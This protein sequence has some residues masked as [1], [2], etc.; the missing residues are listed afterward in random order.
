[1][2]K[3]SPAVSVI[4]PLYNAEKYLGVCLESLL[5]Q[6][7]TDFEIIVVDDCS[8][9]ASPAVAESYLERFGGRLKIVTLEKNTGSGAVPRN[10]GLDLSRGKYVCFVDDDDLLVDTALEELYVAAE[11]Y[12]ADVVYAE[13]I[14]RCEDE[15]PLPTDLFEEPWDSDLKISEPTLAPDDFAE[16]VKSFVD[17]KVRWPPWGKL[18]RREFLI[19]NKIKFLPLTIVE[20]GIWTFELLCLA[21]RWLRVPTP[22]YIYRAHEMSLTRRDR[23]PEQLLQFWTNPLITGVDYMN[24]FMRRFDFLNN[25]PT[26]S[27]RV[28]N[29]LANECFQFMTDAYKKLSPREV[30]EVFLREFKDDKEHAALIAYLMFITNTYRQEITALT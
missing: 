14:W 19:D 21:K 30:F 23:S 16:R 2:K 25:H 6:T 11:E 8:T 27:V 29:V 18:L 13:G 5:I 17:F 12:R 28:L 7:L 24:D 1:M 3:S 4:I 22:F 10:V 20:D 15:E 9:D 26:Y